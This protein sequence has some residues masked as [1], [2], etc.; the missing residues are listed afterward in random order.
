MAKRAAFA[1]DTLG[2]QMIATG[3]VAPVNIYNPDAPRDAPRVQEKDL[4]TGLPLWVADF[5]VEDAQE[6][7]NPAARA[8]V[9][10]VTIAAAQ[11][12]VMPKYQP[13]R[14]SWLRCSIYIAGTG[15]LGLKYTGGLSTAAS[16]GSGQSAKAA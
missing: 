8:N 12:P 9:Q 13:V 16:S 15:H 7:D 10:G 1:L 6:D 3:H 11:Q 2:T 14:F 5:L 4:E